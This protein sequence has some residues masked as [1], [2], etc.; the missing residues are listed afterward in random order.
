MIDFEIKIAEKTL[1][2]LHIKSW[3][4]LSI[5]DVLGKN[6]KKHPVECIKNLN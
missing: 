6:I 2:K 5:D 3:N 4:A 1:K